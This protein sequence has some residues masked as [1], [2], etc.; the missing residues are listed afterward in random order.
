MV[1]RAADAEAEEVVIRDF[2]AC[3][4][5]TSSYGRWRGRNASV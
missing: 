3:W 1:L 4:W 5:G 2:R